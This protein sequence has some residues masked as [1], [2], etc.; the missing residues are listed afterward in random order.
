MVVGLLEKSV[1]NLL[2]EV[3]YHI[4]GFARAVSFSPKHICVRF[5]ASTF[6]IRDRFL[7]ELTNIARIPNF[8]IVTSAASSGIALAILQAAKLSWQ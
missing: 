1:E 7:S 6:S 5:S 2:A 4:V 3:Y 8:R